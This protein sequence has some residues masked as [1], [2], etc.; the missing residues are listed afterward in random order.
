MSHPLLTAP[1]GPALLRLA[2]PTT[3]FMVLQIFVAIA[4]TWFVGRLGTK[5]LAGFAL[6][7]PF[8]V[9]MLNLANGGMGG[10]VAAALARALGAG[11]LDDARALVLHAL[12][13]A[14]AFA[15]LFTAL[16]W[17]AAPA[18]Y[19]LMGGSGPALQ[20]ALIFS[21]IFFGG[22]AAAWVS[23]FLAALLRGAGDSAT[24]ARL[25]VIAS[26]VY[27][28]LSG[29]LALGFGMAGI[30]MASVVASGVAILLLARTV[31]RGGL[32]F[33]LTFAGVRL[34]RRLF[35]EILGVGIMGSFATLTASLAAILMTALVGR[36]GTAALAGYGI[37][38]RLEFMLAPLAFGIG[39]GC[40]TLVGVAAGAGNWRRAVKVAWTGG[41]VA[42]A[43][44]GCIGWTVALLPETWSR[45]FT[46]DPA[47]LAASVGFITRVAPFYC[48]F[49]LGLALNFASQGAGRMKAPL[50]ASLARQAVAVAGGWFAVET[51]GL[52]L[53]SVFVAVAAGMIVYGG[54]IAGPLL[55]SPWRT[56]HRTA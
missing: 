7:L 13:L 44:I 38:L 43:A 40:T 34:Q 16:A 1:I 9:L 18:L 2:G 15:L 47:A 14:L 8:L 24:P 48:L 17:I 3:A 53:E 12:V 5:A 22:A 45:L 54:L 27:V 21:N 36:F 52:G 46:S 20:H 6:V 4:E 55:V 32:G 41:L 37:G 10:A 29:V 26:A 30:A 50:V 23:A 49:G 28:P 51:L 56:R 42:F 39:T 11:R 31:W 35:A 25:G 33:S 19:R